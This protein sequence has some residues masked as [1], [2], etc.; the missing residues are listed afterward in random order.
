MSFLVKIHVSI[1]TIHISCF[2]EIMNMH[3][4][5]KV[6]YSN[7]GR[8]CQI[9]LASGCEAFIGCIDMY[10]LSSLMPVELYR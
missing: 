4:L 7:W 8:S 5:F 10:E 1:L 2:I 9:V 6:I 3:M